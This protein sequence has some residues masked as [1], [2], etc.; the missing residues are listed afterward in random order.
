MKLVF[1]QPQLWR[2]FLCPTFTSKLSGVTCG[3][4]ISFEERF[5]FYLGLREITKVNRD[6]VINKFLDYMTVVL[7][8]Y[9]S[10]LH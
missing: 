7:P 2:S 3:F 8:F 10:L 1:F 6:R 5:T 9:S 4:E